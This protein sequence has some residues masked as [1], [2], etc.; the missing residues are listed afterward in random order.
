VALDPADLHRVWIAR[1]YGSILDLSADADNVY[2]VRGSIFEVFRASDGAEQWSMEGE[3][4]G[5][6]NEGY[7]G[8]PVSDDSLIYLAGSAAVYALRKE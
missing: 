3:E 8:A 7:Y 1:G 6:V 5:A 4:F 2:V